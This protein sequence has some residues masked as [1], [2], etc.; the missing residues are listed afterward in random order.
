[1]TSCLELL[2]DRTRKQLRVEN[3]TTSTKYT[4]DLKIKLFLNQLK[5]SCLSNENNFKCKQTNSNE[6]KSY[7]KSNENS[8]VWNGKSLF[9]QNDTTWKQHNSLQKRTNKVIVNG[10]KNVKTAQN[11]KTEIKKYNVYQN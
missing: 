5:R 8:S 9:N 2:A 10:W 4:D 3:D 7:S 6:W 1:M 11:K